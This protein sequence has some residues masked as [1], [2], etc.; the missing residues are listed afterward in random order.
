LTAV[1]DRLSRDSRAALLAWLREWEQL[2]R[3]LR[4]RGLQRPMPQPVPLHELAGRDGQD[5]DDRTEGRTAP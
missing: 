5:H 4:E 3:L 2:D 1:G